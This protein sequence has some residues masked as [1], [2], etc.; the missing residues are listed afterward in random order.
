MAPVGVPYGIDAI[1]SRGPRAGRRGVGRP[2]I[3]TSGLGIVSVCSRSRVPRPPQRTTTVGL[4]GHLVAREARTDLFHG[5]AHLA[6]DGARRLLE[7]AALADRP[8]EHATAAVW[9]PR[10][11]LPR[12]PQRPR[13]RP[14]PRRPCP[15][16][17][18]PRL[19]PIRRR[20]WW[21]FRLAVSVWLMLECSSRRIPSSLGYRLCADPNRPAANRS[22]G[23]IAPG[24]LYT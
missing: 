21:A 11:C 3:S 20:R 22:H 2:Q 6:D 16:C 23:P 8:A 17:P 24:V 15:C 10:R 1:A 5:L 19:P 7:A 13:R 18:C 12:C 4:F 9:R 14:P